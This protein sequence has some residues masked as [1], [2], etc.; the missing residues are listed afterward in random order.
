MMT[1]GPGAAADAEVPLLGGDVTTGLVRVG[2]TVR[3]PRQPWSASVAA[4][5]R[6][7]EAARF[8][9]APRWH[10]VDDRDRDVLEFLPGD[11]PA[12]PPQPWSATD[13]VLGEVARLL[14]RLHDA[15]AGFVPPADAVWFG[16][17][18]PV[19]LP[20]DARIDEVT[21]LVTHADVTPQNTVFRAGS[22]VALIDFDMTRPTTRLLD[23]INTAMHWVPLGAPADRAPAHAGVDVPGRLRLFVDEYGLGAEDRQA[24][25]PM[26]GRAF[27]RTWHR[28]RANATQRGGGW[29]RMWEEGVGDKILR[30]QRWL[31]DERDHLERALR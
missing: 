12:S 13:Q 11:V 20:E 5:L 9:G 19:T 24:F 14:S 4:Y 28:M 1:G 16:D 26:A 27:R 18:F 31:D 17:D 2:D 6:H 15:S 21:A 25:V 29:R 23:V 10:G 3:R 30:R 22:P 7:L 8:D